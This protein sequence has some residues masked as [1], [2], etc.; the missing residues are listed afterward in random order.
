MCPNY[1]GVK[2]YSANDLS[3]GWAL[4]KAEQII[5]EF[6]AD[7]HIADINTLL[8]LFNVQKLFECGVR[9]IKWSYAEYNQFK[10]KAKTITGV[11]GK[12]FSQIDDSKFIDNYI[13]VDCK[14][15][16]DFWALFEKY[17]WR[18]LGF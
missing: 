13:N 10:S 3:I 12:F 2:F 8:E 17:K 11:L 16:D 7:D 15:V 14:Y 1:R 5:I 18:L 9:L 6:N 4:E